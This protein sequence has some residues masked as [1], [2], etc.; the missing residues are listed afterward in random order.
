M[1]PHCTHVLFKLLL[2]VLMKMSVMLQCFIYHGLYFIAMFL[3]MMECFLDRH[4]SPYDEYEHLTNGWGYKHLFIMNCPLG[5]RF[6]AIC[7]DGDI[8]MPKCPFVM[9]IAL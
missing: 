9:V 5:S 2:I 4:A 3:H 1:T 8:F 6:E 7:N